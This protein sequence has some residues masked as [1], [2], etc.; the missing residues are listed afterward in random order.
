LIDPYNTRK[1]IHTMNYKVVKINEYRYLADIHLDAFHGFFLSSLGKRFLNAYYN[2]AL[3]STEAIAVCAVDDHEQIQGFATGCARSQGFHKRLIL[4]NISKFLFQGLFILFTNPKALM[5][6]IRNL[7]KISNEN[8]D[9]NYA[10]LISI[11]VSQSSKGLGVGKKLIK[12]FEEEAKRR[13]CQKITL[14]TD[15]YNNSEVVE[16]YFHS[17]YNVFYEFM[18]YPKRKMYKLI[19]DL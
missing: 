17:G 9:G 13:G 5:R 15:Y 4:K 1:N 14:T 16:F 2:A 19:K 11:G 12:V 18:A 7:D 3:K 6:L 8:D 10:E